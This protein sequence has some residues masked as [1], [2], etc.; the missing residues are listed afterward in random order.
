MNLVHVLLFQIL[1]FPQMM[2]AINSSRAK[3][4][5]TQEE[6]VAS[7]NAAWRKAGGCMR[8]QLRSA[9]LRAG[10]SDHFLGSLPLSWQ[11]QYLLH[12]LLFQ[13]DTRSTSGTF[14]ALFMLDS[15]SGPSSHTIRPPPSK[16]HQRS[17]ITSK[18]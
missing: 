12:L 14:V 17:S 18:S 10:A 6:A 4:H 9:C 1:V 13:S 5:E 8:Q 16:S 11:L 15:G 7:E 2:K 3:K